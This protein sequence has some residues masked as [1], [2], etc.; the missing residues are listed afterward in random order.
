M[1]APRTP[2]ADVEQLA[3]SASP[4]RRRSGSQN[5]T[6]EIELALGARI[7]AARIAAKMNQSD[8]GATVGISFQQV[9]K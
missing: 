8:L 2:K 5:R 1:Q 4:T 9:Q 6:P 3:K 7:R